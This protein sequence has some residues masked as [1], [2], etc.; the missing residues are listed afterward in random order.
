MR[1]SLCFQK[2]W[3]PNLR[4]FVM[5]YFSTGKLRKKNLFWTNKKFVFFFNYW[6]WEKFVENIGETNWW[7]H[8]MN[9]LQKNL[10]KHVQNVAGWFYAQENIWHCD[11]LKF[12]LF[13]VWKVDFRFPNGLK[14]LSNNQKYINT[15]ALMI[16]SVKVQYD[17]M[18]IRQLPV[19][20]SFCMIWS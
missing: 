15:K 3:I 13:G 12:T 1:N 19:F 11:V 16:S 14:I 6:N 20:T 9:S 5:I 8:L 18:N 4:I 2:S 10:P 17:L 7:K